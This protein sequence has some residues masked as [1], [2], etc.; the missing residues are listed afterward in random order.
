MEDE[1]RR[2]REEE[3][4]EEKP[5]GRG[6]GRGRGRAAKAKAKGQAKPKAVPKR[7]QTKAQRKADA[8]EEEAEEAEEECPE[9]EES[10]A[11]RGPTKAV[12]QKVR[13]AME[14]W[15]PQSKLRRANTHLH[16]SVEVLSSGQSAPSKRVKAHL[17]SAKAARA[18]K[19]KAKPAV[20]RKLDNEFEAAAGKGD[21]E[22]PIKEA[23]GRKSALRK[24][25]APLPQHS[26]A[27]PAPPPKS[28]KVLPQPRSKKSDDPNF[29]EA[30]LYINLAILQNMKFDRSI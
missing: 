1:D 8:D 22:E 27:E 26:S 13:Q 3:E 6:R 17:E 23:P 29:L 21:E 9:A 24:R 10:E 11:A 20:V 2:L 14:K 25:P 18:S 28:Q 15:S 12:K 4:S 7:K 30:R 5:K 19:A 16:S